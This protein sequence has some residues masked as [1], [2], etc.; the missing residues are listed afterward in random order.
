MNLVELKAAVETAIENVKE[1]GEEDLS[2]V[3]VSIQIN[4]EDGDGYWAVDD[5]ECHYDNNLTASGFVI[6]G[7]KDKSCTE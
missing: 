3:S 2:E 7:T 4:D 6:T 1:Y 5:I